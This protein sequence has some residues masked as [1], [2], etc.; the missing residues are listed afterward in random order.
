MTDN[1]PSQSLNVQC[2]RLYFY[3]SLMKTD[4]KWILGE[5]NSNYAGY[6][7]LLILIVWLV[8][9]GLLKEGN[10]IFLILVVFTIVIKKKSVKSWVS[11]LSFSIQ[12]KVCQGSIDNLI[13]NFSLVWRRL[14]DR[15]PKAGHLGYVDNKEIISKDALFFLLLFWL[16]RWTWM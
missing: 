12:G 8:V 15:G 3:F 9:V 14:H 1:K 4:K 2:Q 16:F 10:R 6:A 13:V 5:R 7:H 11:L